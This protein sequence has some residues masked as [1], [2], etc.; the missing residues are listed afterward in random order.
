MF[1]VNLHFD[2]VVFLPRQPFASFLSVKARSKLKLFFAFADS[3][4]FLANHT[5]LTNQT[6]E[7]ILY[8]VPFMF[9]TSWVSVI[10]HRRQIPMIPDVA[11][12]V[13]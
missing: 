13:Q 1:R 2:R 11:D 7:R 9:R 6:F 4:Y 12:V 8:T 10:P 5:S 3:C